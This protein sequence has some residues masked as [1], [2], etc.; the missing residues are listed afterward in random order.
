MDPCDV[1]AADR[2]GDVVERIAGHAPAMLGARLL[3]GF[4]DDV[5]NEF[6]QLQL[7]VGWGWRRAAR[8]RGRCAAGIGAV[9]LAA[10]RRR[11]CVLVHAARQ[12]L[13]DRLWLITRN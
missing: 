4:D 12:L 9:T 6:G 1:A 7:P 13:C 8:P 5:G 11:F 2:V 10:S 3:Q